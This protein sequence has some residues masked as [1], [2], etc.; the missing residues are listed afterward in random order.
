LDARDGLEQACMPA[1][2]ACEC[3]GIEQPWHAM[4]ENGAIVSARRVRQR[5]G[6]P[7]FTDASQDSVTMPGVWRS[8]SGS[9]IRFILVA[10]KWCWSRSGGSSQA[11]VTW[12]W[13]S[14]T[15]RSL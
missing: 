9:T 13:F 6:D 1:V 3:Q 12:S 8:R 11:R 5:A 7:T 15:A 10:A 2:T 4:I 14:Q